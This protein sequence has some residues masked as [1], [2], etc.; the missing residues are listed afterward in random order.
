MTTEGLDA[1]FTVQE[2]KPEQF[3]GQLERAGLRLPEQQRAELTAA[4]VFLSFAAAAQLAEQDPAKLRGANERQLMA[5]SLT[6]L[7]RYARDQGRSMTLRKFIDLSNTLKQEKPEW[8]ATF[9]KAK[10]Q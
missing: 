3:P 6:Y 1:S 9:L 5:I 10:G 8:W 7:Y 4:M 2:G